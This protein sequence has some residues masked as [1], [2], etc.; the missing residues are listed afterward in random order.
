MSVHTPLLLYPSCRRCAS[1]NCS[2]C[3]CSSVREWVCAGRTPVCWIN[4]CRLHCLSSLFSSSS[5]SCLTWDRT[6][7]GSVWATEKRE[8]SP[9]RT[10]ILKSLSACKY[11]C[12]VN[13]KWTC[14]L[15]SAF[16]TQ[17]HTRSKDHLLAWRD[18]RS[19][20]HLH[21]NHWTNLSI[22]I[23]TG[24]TSTCWSINITL[25]YLISMITVIT[26]WP[27][28]LF[29][30]EAGLLYFPLGPLGVNEKH[31]FARRGQ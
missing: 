24:M 23:W 19:H 28:N 31:L 8:N 22:C 13:G 7:H 25:F 17:S 21:T 10:D 1:S 30:Y 16:Q 5:S 12:N 2:S 27:Q 14:I 11:N 26:H 4:C 6:E 15:Y 9:V 3:S 29:I 20:T 18:N